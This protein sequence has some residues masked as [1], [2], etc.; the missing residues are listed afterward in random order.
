VST[1]P[2]RA[3][4]TPRVAAD[5]FDYQLHDVR[6]PELRRID[7]HGSTLVG[8]PIENAYSDQPPPVDAHGR[9]IERLPLASG[10]W[11]QF[12]PPLDEQGQIIAHLTVDD[13]VRKYVEM[14]LAE[15]VHEALEWTRVDGRPYLDPHGP[16]QDRIHRAVKRQQ[17][18]YGARA[19]N[20][21]PPGRR[22]G[23]TMYF[24]EGPV[25]AFYRD[26][27]ERKRAHLTRPSSGGDPDEL[28]DVAAAAKLLGYKSDST[29]RSYLA[30][31]E[32]FPAP[33]HVEPWGHRRRR[34]RRRTLLAF[35]AARTGP[36]RGRSVATA[37]HPAVSQPG[38]ESTTT[39]PPGSGHL[40]DPTRPPIPTDEGSE[41][42]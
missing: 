29:I 5:R 25:R 22:V 38:P 11:E 42:P 36:G 20:G 12:D 13:Y 9:A 2:E 8:P 10:D 4:D 41:Q 6:S 24:E 26:H 31:G 39:P 37:L 27:L 33:D 40:D 28:L 21:H 30:R 1:D 14:A 23:R 17:N 18:L 15:A 35:A 7:G 3:D 34:W 32:H 19:E 16:S